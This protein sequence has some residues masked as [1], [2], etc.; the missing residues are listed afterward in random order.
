VLI[1][2]ASFAYREEECEEKESK[3]NIEEARIVV[4]YL[5]SLIDSGLKENQIAI[6]SPYSAQ[7]LLLKSLIS[8]DH[9]FVEI[10]TGILF[11]Y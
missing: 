2:T 7:V 9:E 8:D 11:F 3:S 5:K 6:I 4:K 10:G 1:D